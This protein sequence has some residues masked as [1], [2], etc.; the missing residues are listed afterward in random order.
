MSLEPLKHAQRERI[1]FLDQCL[2]WRGQANRRDLIQRFDISTA[3]AANDFRLYLALTQT[4]PRY[5]P[6]EKTY[7]PRSDHQPLSASGPEQVFD[8]LAD[9][10]MQTPVPMRASI[11]QPNRLMDPA[12]LAQLY[13]AM[14]AGREIQ[15][16]YTS[17]TSGLSAPQ[18]IAPVRFHFDGEAIHLRAWSHKHA[19]YRDYLPIRIAQQATTITRA[20][21]APL[22]HDSDWHQLVRLWI[23]PRP[24]LSEEQARV[25]RLEYGF[26]GQGHLAIDT[27]KA[28]AF[29]V[30]R[31]WRLE[32]DKARLVLDRIED[33]AG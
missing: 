1:L 11:P 15:I 2:T 17:M 7:F 30:I 29:Y 8:L 32:D 5:D 18:W 4:P 22:P 3:Q 6:A 23:C 10:P 28:L 25:V 16:T 21:A 20:R 19:A 13:R 26:Q 31:R 12:V 27:R 33:I 9:A 24:D 14:T